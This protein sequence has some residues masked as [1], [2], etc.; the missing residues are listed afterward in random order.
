MKKIIMVSFMLLVWASIS[1]ASTIGNAVEVSVITDNGRMLPFY[2]VKSRHN[3]KK[4]ML[5][6]S[7]VIIT[8]LSYA[9]N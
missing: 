6:P 1:A 2:Q 3:L 5:K 4:V 9:T 8:G 7:G